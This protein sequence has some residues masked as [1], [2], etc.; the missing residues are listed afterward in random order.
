VKRTSADG[1]QANKNGTGR[2]GFKDT[3]ANPTTVD[4]SMLNSFQEEIARAVELADI[5]LDGNNFEQL[6]A[7]IMRSG[8]W[9]AAHNWTA[10][11]TSGPTTEDL[12]AAASDG[13]G[14]IIVVGDTA[15][16][17]VSTDGGLTWAVSTAAGSITD[18]LAATWGENLFVIAGTGTNRIQTSPDGVTWTQ[19]TGFPATTPQSASYGNGTFVTTWSS[20][21]IYTSPDGITWTSQTGVNATAACSGYGGGLFVTAGASGEIQT[22]ANATSWTART[23]GASYTGTWRGHAYGHGMH[24]L[25]GD[26]GEIQTS[27]DGITW[28]HRTSGVSAALR[29]VGYGNGVFVV[30]TDAHGYALISRD[31]IN[32]TKAWLPD[33]GDDSEFVCFDGQ[34]FIIAGEDGRLLASLKSGS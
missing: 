27:P 24:V 20:G 19:R 21:A 4:E 23:A 13:A 12:E 11:T 29:G 33:T 31:G 5:T 30:A 6:A 1:F 26:T 16:I 14:R 10:R 8:V 9:H 32:W 25:V 7:A 3:G 22:S 15:T 34:G 2:N 18:I 17:Q 28:T